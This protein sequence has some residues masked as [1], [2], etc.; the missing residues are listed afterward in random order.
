MAQA[1]ITTPHVTPRIFWHSLKIKVN[2]IHVGNFITP[3]R[4]THLRNKDNTTTFPDLCSS[5]FPSR[6]SC[7]FYFYY[8]CSSRPMGISI[9]ISWVRK[10]RVWEVKGFVQ[11]WVVGRVIILGA[12]ESMVSAPTTANYQNKCQVTKQSTSKNWSC[13]N[14]HKRMHTS[15]CKQH[16]RNIVGKWLLAI[17][18][19]I[20]GELCKQCETAING[21]LHSFWNPVGD[22]TCVH[23]GDVMLFGWAV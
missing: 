19:S 16:H 8:R 5:A 18:L 3:P 22:S 9:P 10:L 2:Y 4:L 14:G 23:R 7:S 21:I 17:W 12:P 13:R 11:E 15:E 6:H 1:H 20:N